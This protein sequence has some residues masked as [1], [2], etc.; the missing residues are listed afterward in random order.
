MAR[1]GESLVTNGYAVCRSRRA[2]R[3]PAGLSGVDGW[4]TRTGRVTPNARRPGPKSQPGR[5]GPMP[6]SA[7]SAA[8]LRLS[9]ST[10]P[11]MPNLP[12]ASRPSPENGSEP[13]RLSVSARRPSASSSIGRRRRSRASG[14]IR[15][16]CFASVSSS[17]PC[18]PSRNRRPYDWPEET[19]AGGSS[20]STACR[21]SMKPRRGPSFDEAF[22]LLPDGSGRRSCRVCR[23]TWRTRRRDPPAHA[24]AGTLPAIRA[25]LAFIPNAELDYDSWIRIGLALKGALGETGADLFASWSAQAVKNDAAVTDTTWAGFKP[26]SIGAG[27]IYHLAMVQGWKPD[28]GLVLDGSGPA[29]PCSPGGGIAGHD[30]WRCD[31]RSSAGEAAT[32]RSGH[33]GRDRRQPGVLHR[34]DRASAAATPVAGCESVRHRR[35]DGPAISNREQPPL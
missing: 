30:R 27:T 33:P 14:G 7:S 5:S 16:R 18:D 25:A 2:P 20:I 3:S 32:L 35:A 21:R 26:N 28:A 15:W 9:T 23:C 11:T 1:F 13:P 17:S 8:R 29:D 31:W 12:N 24:Q 22:A 34:R 10:S 4:I 19:L 6:A